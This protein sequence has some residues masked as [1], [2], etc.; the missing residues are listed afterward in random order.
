[1]LY[2]S[3]LET[4]ET[5]QSKNSVGK[6]IVFEG[7]DFSGKTTQA[8][9]L[10][11]WLHKMDV[12]HVNTFEPNDPKIRNLLLNSF[13]DEIDDKTEL[14]LFMTDRCQHINKII[15]PNLNSGNW[16]ICDRFTWSTLVY[17]GYGK[18][19]NVY[20]IETLNGIATN[21]IK[22]DLTIYL[23]LT[24]DEQVRRRKKKLLDK[25]ESKPVQYFIDVRSG[26]QKILENEKL[27]NPE[28]V[29][30]IK[31]YGLSMDIHNKIVYN[32][33]NKFKEFFNAIK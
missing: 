29:L 17:Q 31:A 4:R 15:F 11:E 3:K 12:S 1:M 28:K 24:L 16:V 22:P 18:N 32:V 21:Y 2:T 7:M 20:E 13:N 6:F 27:L 33:Y 23:D 10:S 30:E 9:M 25:F 8:R 14:F 19:L 26:Y 5:M